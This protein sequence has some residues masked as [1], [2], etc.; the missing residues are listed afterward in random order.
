MSTDNVNEL[1][2]VLDTV[3]EKIPNLIKGILE[4]IYSPQSGKQVGETIGNLYKELI[5]SGMP[6]EDAIEISKD[7]LK[8]IKEFKDFNGEFK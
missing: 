8:F 6:K 3:S 5:N 1:K 7:Y 2:E 4:T